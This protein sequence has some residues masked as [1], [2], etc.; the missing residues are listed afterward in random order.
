M[1]S[2]NFEL[3]V[4]SFKVKVPSLFVETPICAK[5]LLDESKPMIGSDKILPEGSMP[6]IENLVLGF[7]N[8]GLITV[9]SLLVMAEGLVATGV[10]SYLANFFESD[11]PIPEEA[12]VII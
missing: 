1:F 2:S 3:K 5:Y 11:S 12:P 4:C 9:V 7:S 10:I 6:S 8:P